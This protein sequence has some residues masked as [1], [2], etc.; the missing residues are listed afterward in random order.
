MNSSHVRRGA[1]WAAVAFALA[2]VGCGGESPTGPGGGGG[3]GGGGGTTPVATTSV[4][5]GDT[6]FNPP[7]IVVTSA[8]TVTWTFSGSFAHNVT[9]TS[10]VIADSPDQTSGMFATAM[11]SAPGTYSYSCTLHPGL[12]TGSVLVQ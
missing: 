12:M 7:H 5:V 9:F 3:G 4:S 2:L 11:P 8:A 6:F 1:S 10:T